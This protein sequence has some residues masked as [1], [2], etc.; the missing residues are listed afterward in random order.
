MQTVYTSH[1]LLI[2]VPV[3][4][5]TSCLPA[6]SHVIYVSAYG[7]F[8]PTS[9]L[10]A[11]KLAPALRNGLAH[12]RQRLLDAGFTV[13][14]F[15]DACWA[16]SDWPPVAF[17]DALYEYVYDEIL[18]E[19][20]AERLNRTVLQTGSILPISLPISRLAQ[21]RIVQNKYHI[22][23][24]L[25][26][27]HPSLYKTL[28]LHS[29]VL[30]A[31]VAHGLGNRLR[32]L[33]SSAEHASRSNYTFMVIW[34]L[35][36]HCNAQF[37]DLF[38]RPPEWYVDLG[39]SGS[40]DNWAVYDYM[41]GERMEVGAG[42]RVLY[43]GAYVMKS[44]LVSWRGSNR[45][46]RGLRAVE[47]VRRRVEAVSPRMGGC[48]GVHVRNLRVGEDII[49]VNGTA[50]YG[51][52]SRRTIDYW[53]AVSSTG[54]FARELS[55]LGAGN[56]FVAADNARAK[57]E[58]L[59]VAGAWGI[60]ACMGRGR[61]CVRDALVE[62]VLLGRCGVVLGSFWSSFSEIVQRLGGGVR[63]AGVDFGGEG[64]VVVKVGKRR[65]RRK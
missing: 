38:E 43:R 21:L 12:L 25:S 36:R 18:A 65:K 62:M 20:L 52:S 39:V 41:H 61:R 14:G 59:G 63:F 1:T 33:I 10:Q 13:R 11:N 47:A 48:T 28:P 60:E 34:G 30:I 27:R 31:Q 24:S 23:H 7:L 42:R 5:D 54:A 29:G 8:I 50:E 19:R 15:P 55:S 56:V 46:L 45:I 9:V 32:A 2:T 49:G 35:D 6:P 17:R 44:R 3:L 53:R 37:S 26:H 51:A 40:W 22:P 4:P 64:G 16:E 58:L 57:R